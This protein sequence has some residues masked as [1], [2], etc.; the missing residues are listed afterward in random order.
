MV[1]GVSSDIDG[2]SNL[3]EIINSLVVL[4]VLSRGE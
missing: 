1:N 3:D 4:K 2:A